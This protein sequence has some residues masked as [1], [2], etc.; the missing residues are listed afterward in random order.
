VMNDQRKVMYEQRSEVM[1]AAAVDDVVLDMRVDTLNAIVG[2]ACPPGSYPEQWD[3]PALKARVL[4]VTGLELPIEA[5][6][7][8]ETVEPEPPAERRPVVLVQAV[9]EHQQRHP[10][11]RPGRIGERP[12]RL[13]AAP[14]RGG[15]RATDALAR[16]DVGDPAGRAVA[17]V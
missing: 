16:V 9:E 1:D 17:L 4:E 11:T 3:V 13:P 15:E 10:V 6:M 12:R 7:S 8:E 5:W 2:T 14:P